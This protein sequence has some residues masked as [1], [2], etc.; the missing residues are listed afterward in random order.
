MV[1][2]ASVVSNLLPI[3]NTPT[4]ES[5]V[6]SGS[7]LAGDYGSRKMETEKACIGLFSGFWILLDL[8]SGDTR[9]N[10]RNLVGLRIRAFGAI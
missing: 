2:A 7:R 5:Q 9:T 3:G 6:Q 8:V 1:E 10:P 4:H